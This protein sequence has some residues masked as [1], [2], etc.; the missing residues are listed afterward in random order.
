MSEPGQKESGENAKKRPYL[1]APSHR[2]A[3]GP[4]GRSPQADSLRPVEGVNYGVLLDLAG[5][6]LRRQ[7]VSVLKSY[8]NHLGDLHLR[9]VETAALIL[10]ESNKDITQ[11]A[12]ANALGTDQS[13][14][15]G[16]STRLEERELIERRR[17]A[18]DRRYQILNLTPT[19]R[20]LAT[21]VKKRLLAHNENIL[22]RLSP[23]ERQSFF[24]ILTKIIE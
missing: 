13:T 16:I 7:Q 11:N 1:R 19:G 9:P 8:G 5:F 2:G 17:Q 14:M 24:D 3:V 10:L 22:R 23:N 4:N 12:L 18:N 21:T 15:V 6:W 20:K